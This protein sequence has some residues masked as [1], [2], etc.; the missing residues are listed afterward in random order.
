[1]GEERCSRTGAAKISRKK[2]VSPKY[3][4]LTHPENKSVK[5]GYSTGTKGKHVTK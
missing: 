1:M 2:V 5:E 3:G 4:K